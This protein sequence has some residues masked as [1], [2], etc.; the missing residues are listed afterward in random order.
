MNNK[1]T[2]FTVLF[3]TSLTLTIGFNVAIAQKSSG[4]IR[5]EIIDNSELENAEILKENQLKQVVRDDVTRSV[6]TSKNDVRFL[7]RPKN[8][9]VIASQMG[10]VISNIKYNVGQ[11]FK[12]GESLI[13]LRCG[14]QNAQLSA[15]R[16]RVQEYTLTYQSNQDLLKGN[17]VSQYEV[18]IAKAQ[19]NQQRALLKESSIVASS[20]QV[21][22]PFSGGVVSVEANEFET[23]SSGAPL[24]KVIDDS[25]LIMSLNIPS[26]LINKVNKGNF[27]TITVD[28]TSNSYKAKVTGVSPAIDPVS[29]TIELRAV[30]VK[31][32]PELRPGMSGSAKLDFS[33]K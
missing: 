13:S 20:C 31:K 14:V 29:K 18:D 15:Q 16:A 2:K 21:R 9:A 26:T 4:V 12:K 30:L 8:E 28:E 22:A 27:F 1:I 33:E 25:S 3:S 5:G 6:K 10:G 17:A 7:L 19:L 24:L 23:I 11:R 32:S